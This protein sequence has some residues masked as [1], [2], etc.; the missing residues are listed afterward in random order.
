M[1]ARLRRFGFAI[2]G[3]ALAACSQKASLPIASVGA[4][5][6]LIVAT[7]QQIVLDGSKSD[8]KGAP[9]LTYQWSLKTLPRGSK[10][11]IEAPTN[12]ITRFTPDVATSV[13]EQYVVQLVVRNQYYVSE[14]K[15]LTITAL[16]CGVN[17][18][19]ITTLTANPA[20]GAV[21]VPVLLTA[22]VDDKANDA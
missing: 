9:P 13:A 10:A 21:D 12:A 8:A 11:K 4:V 5:G 20:A 2:L 19:A 6:A 3:L 16:E 17:A 7:G 1:Q 15:E 14:P 22:V 18:P